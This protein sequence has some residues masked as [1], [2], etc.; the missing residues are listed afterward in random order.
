MVA[1]AGAG[2]RPDDLR[3]HR[4]TL[5]DAFVRLTGASGATATPGAAGTPSAT[6]RVEA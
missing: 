4:S 5:E 1:L 2:V 3:V 6:D